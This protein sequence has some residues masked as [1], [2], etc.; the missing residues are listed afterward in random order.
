MIVLA[1][2]AA[3]VTFTPNPSHFGE[4]VTARV[5]GAASPGFAPFVVREQHGSTYVLQCLDPVCV[6]GPKPRVLRVAGTRVVIVPSTTTAEV[7]HPLRSFRRQTMPPPTSYAVRPGLLR[8]LLV[9][10]AALLVAGAAALLVP[11]LRRLVPEP[12]DDRTP[13]QRALDLVR[14][15]LTR[16][17]DDRRRA[18]DLLARTVGRDRARAALDLAWSRPQPDPAR[19]ESLADSVERGER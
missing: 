18:L 5:Q 13:L 19:V 10:G 9:G 4:L 11:L 7:A 3:L 14:A 8:A 17:P 6:P 1:A 2:A 15:S 16:G 12:R